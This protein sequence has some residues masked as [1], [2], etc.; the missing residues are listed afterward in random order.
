[1]CVRALKAQT[2][3]N[4]PKQPPLGSPATPLFMAQEP[5][6][7]HP[8]A[9]SPDLS[10]MTTPAMVT[11]LSGLHPNSQTDSVAWPQPCPGTVDL[12]G[13]AGGDWHVAGAVRTQQPR[14]HFDMEG[15]SWEKGLM[16]DSPQEKLSSV[17]RLRN[18][19]TKGGEAPS[20]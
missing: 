19:S 17:Q 10:H 18:T 8:G 14:L 12:P 16:L 15:G 9:F 5:L 3:S 1:M 20:L 7:A 6:S 2:G 13:R 4:Q 11:A